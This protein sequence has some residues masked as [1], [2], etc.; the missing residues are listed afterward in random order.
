MREYLYWLIIILLTGLLVFG[1]L[2]IHLS[3]LA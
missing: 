3:E 2:M 1:A